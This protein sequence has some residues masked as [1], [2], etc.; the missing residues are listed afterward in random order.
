[1]AADIPVVPVKCGTQM[2]AEHNGQKIVIQCVPND[3][4]TPVTPPSVTGPRPG[5]GFASY[6]VSFENEVRSVSIDDL[7]RATQPQ[8]QIEVATPRLTTARIVEHEVDM[9]HFGE[10]YDRM[11]RTEDSVIV[12]HVTD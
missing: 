10:D 3:D 2:I 5:G 11:T 1:M 8:R 12:F 7:V 9:A 4:D 6:V